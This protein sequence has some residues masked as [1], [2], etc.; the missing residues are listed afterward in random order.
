M[1]QDIKLLSYLTILILLFTSCT[2]SRIDDLS[3]YNINGIQYGVTDGNFRARWWNFYERGRSFSDGGFL[4]E[5]ELDLQRALT[6]RKEDNRRLRTYGLHLIQYFANR[7]IGVVLYK[8]G[9]LSKAIHYLDKSL[10]QEPSEKAEFYLNLCQQQLSKHTSDNEPP[11]IHLNP[12]PSVTNSSQLILSGYVE[13]NNFVHHIQIN[14]IKLN[15]VLKEKRQTFC[16]KL[17]LHPGQ[18]EISISAVDTVKNNIQKTHNII[19]DNEPPLISILYASEKKIIISVSDQLPVHLQ[20]ATI[21]NLTLLQ[22]NVN[23]Y[24]FKPAAGSHFYH[25]EFEDLAHNVNGISFNDTT[26]KLGRFSPKAYPLRKNRYSEIL[27]VSSKLPK[28]ITRPKNPSQ[29]NIGKDLAS[30]LSI[31]IEQLL[32][33]LIVYQDNI[34][35][36]GRINGEFT[37][38]KMDKLIKLPKGKDVRFCFRKYLKPGDNI[39]TLRATDKTKK[40]LTKTYK[41]KRLKSPE[42]NRKLRAKIIVLPSEIENNHQNITFIDFNKLSMELDRNGRF[43]ILETE[44]LDIINRELTLA[45]NRWIKNRKATS[46]G[47]KLHADYTLACTIRPTLKDVEIFGRLIDNYTSKILATC[48][49]Y[50]LYDNNVDS[51]IINT[52]KRFSQKLAQNFPIVQETLTHYNKKSLILNIGKNANIK[53]GMKF[54]AYHREK[55]LIDSETGHII[56]NGEI[57]IDAIL[58]AGK[59]NQKRTYLKNMNNN[60][61][62]NST[63]VISK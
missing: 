59:V 8:Q 12:L 39:L 19:L 5:A 23:E 7:E 16:N 40:T 54:I 41:I 63:F 1:N 62:H 45:R 31:D 48:D 17:K 38:L 56:V 35:V 18:N 3:K 26:L 27:L 14:D 20:D 21:K 6:S 28:T 4:K 42:E 46:R 58:S 30:E 61:S 52:F 44:H 2:T 32:P 22:K 53:T 24:V 29:L 11:S 50:S 37:N 47:K 49:A 25:V 43:R 13:D 34:L 55:P 10:K 57:S 15:P 33:E 60:I 51:E 36:A 9:Q